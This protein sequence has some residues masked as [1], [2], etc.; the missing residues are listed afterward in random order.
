MTQIWSL[1]GSFGRKDLTWIDAEK[2][3]KMLGGKNEK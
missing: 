3:I 2:V 1:S